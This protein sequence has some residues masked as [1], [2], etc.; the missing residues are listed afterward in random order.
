MEIS[1]KNLRDKP[2]I[3]F[4]V[5][6][7]WMSKLTTEEIELWEKDLVERWMLEDPKMD[8]AGLIFRLT[9]EVELIE[10]DYNFMYH[11]NI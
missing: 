8:R 1:V 4:F 6:Y 11:G 2:V 3:N 9:K 7:R 10:R 5:S